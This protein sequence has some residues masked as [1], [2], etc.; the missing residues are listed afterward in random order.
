MILS[1]IVLLIPLSL[2]VAV[3]RLRGGEDIVVVDPAPAIAQAQSA[4]LF[5][6]VAPLGLSPEW[7]AVRAAFQT[8]GSQGTLRVGYVTPSGG[9]V[10]LVESNEGTAS[11]LARELGNDVRPQGEVTINGRL[12]RSSNVRGDEG[13]LV[14]TS[15]ERTVIVVGHAPV[16]E[17]TTLAASLR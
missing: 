10:Q 6:V 2:I 11:V 13:A 4:N 3:F 16:Q 15:N 7:K 9:T 14:D 5:P 12:W 8:S 1:I 17:L